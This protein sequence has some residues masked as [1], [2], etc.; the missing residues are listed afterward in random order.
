MIFFVKLKEVGFYGMLILVVI[1]YFIV[2]Y[3][4]KWEIKFLKD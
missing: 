2:F 3:I 1:L 4:V